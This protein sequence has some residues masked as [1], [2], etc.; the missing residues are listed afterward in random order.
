MTALGTLLGLV[1]MI[2]GYVAAIA[3]SSATMPS[4]GESFD[5]NPQAELASYLWPIMAGL[6]LGLGLGSFQGGVLQRIYGEGFAG[7]WTAATM[8][9]SVVGL[10]V[11]SRLMDLLE[12]EIRSFLEPFFLEENI[13][14]V[15]V[16]GLA[17]GMVVGLV[18]G[19]AQVTIGRVVT[20]IW[21]AISGVVWGAGFA[22]PA[23][24]AASS[25]YRETLGSM[26]YAPGALPVSEIIGALGIIALAMVLATSF[27]S[28]VLPPH[29]RPLSS[30]SR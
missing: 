29:L 30:E 27:V 7:R 3:I 4:S 14:P 17:A 13:V 12:G 19:A 24:V 5:S 8:V 18:I 10:T 20:G 15:I 22:L 23:T 28:F 21:P 16:V 2:G 11:M 1:L 6:G 9:G 26:V 25:A